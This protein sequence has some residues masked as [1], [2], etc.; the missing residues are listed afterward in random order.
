MVLTKIRHNT[1]DPGG[2]QQQQQRK[3][4][5]T[6]KE[7]P[8]FNSFD[9][10]DRLR[11]SSAFAVPMAGSNNISK[12]RRT[13]FLEEGLGVSRRSVQPRRQSTGLLEIEYAQGHG[14]RDF[15]EI[16]GIRSESAE[17]LGSDGGDCSGE[18]GASGHRVGNIQDEGFKGAGMT[19]W[20]SKLAPGSRRPRI[21]SATSAHPP[22]SSVTMARV[23]MIALLIA[24]IFPSS[25]Y[26]NGCQ[27]VSLG[28]TD[29]A[30]IETPSGPHWA[31]QDTPTEVCARW[32]GQCK[33]P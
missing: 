27:T 5:A 29:A 15:D 11:E 22:P 31:R 2:Q 13:I 20:L 33:L 19:R 17:D 1:S 16:T 18:R 26:H 7:R 3:R 12:G 32:A 30:M 24:I 6:T 28:G 21:R 23:A 14:G 9:T 25:S 10:S 8:K 4:A